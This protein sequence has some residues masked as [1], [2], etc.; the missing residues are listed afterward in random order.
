MATHTKSVLIV[1]DNFILENL[2][3]TVRIITGP[4]GIQNPGRKYK[5]AM[6]M[7]NRISFQSIKLM[8]AQYL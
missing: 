4:K 8:R 2:G 5:H 6:I 3:D 7:G 1:I